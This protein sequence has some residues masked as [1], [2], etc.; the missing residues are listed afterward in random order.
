LIDLKYFNQVN[1][2]V[3]SRLIVDNCDCNNCATKFDF[4]NA[5]E[6]PYILDGCG[7]VSSFNDLVNQ[8]TLASPGVVDVV[9][10][11][12]KILRWSAS[13]IRVRPQRLIG[14]IIWIVA[15]VT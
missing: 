11:G 12:R 5:L 6:S 7:A 15:S 1:Q 9:S 2:S 3:Q 10:G 14:C 4:N 8:L 13:I